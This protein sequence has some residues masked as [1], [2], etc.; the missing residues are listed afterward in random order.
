MRGGNLVGA[1]GRL[2]LHDHARV[3]REAGGHRATHRAHAH[4]AD[5][6]GRVAHGINTG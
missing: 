4:D 2:V 3:P 6:G 1:A 5:G